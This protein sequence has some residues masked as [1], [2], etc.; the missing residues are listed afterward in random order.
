M[1]NFVQCDNVKKESFVYEEYVLGINGGVY[2]DEEVRRCSGGCCW[3]EMSAP[4][5]PKFVRRP[6]F[7]W[8]HIILLSKR[9]SLVMVTSQKTL[10]IC[11][12]S[13]VVTMA[14]VFFLILSLHRVILSLK[15]RT[16]ILL[17]KPFLCIISKQTCFINWGA[18]CSRYFKT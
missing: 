1:T 15:Q 13:F 4:Y 6:F 10:K 16:I 9:S 14:L 2:H 8:L 3:E 12:L 18:H 11:F 17:L 5:F 7:Q